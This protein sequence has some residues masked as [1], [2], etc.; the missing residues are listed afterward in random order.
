MIVD[1][2]ASEMEQILM[3]DHEELFI[4]NCKRKTIFKNRLIQRYYEY[5][6]ALYYVIKNH[7]KYEC[8]LFWQQIIGFFA[9]LYFSR[10]QTEKFIISSVL[11][12]PD[13]TPRFGVKR[14]LLFNAI[15]KA[16]AVL[17]FSEEMANATKRRYPMISPKIHSTLI[18]VFAEKQV[19]NGDLKNNSQSDLEG[20]IFCGGQSDRDF[21]TI[22]LAFRNT[23]IPVTIVCPDNYEIAMLSLATNNITIKRFSEVSPRDYYDLVRQSFCVVVSLKSR[24]SSCGQ[25]LF[26]FCMQNGIPIIA[27][28]SFGTRDY[29]KD[30]ENGLLVPIG[31]HVAFQNA[32]KRLRDNKSFRLR[33]IDRSKDIAESM[34]FANYLAKI[35]E[36]KLNENTSHNK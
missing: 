33:L 13:N 34:T 29:I 12:S 26:S 36:I 14:F 20:G 7:S 2:K 23:N 32:Y 11:Y 3:S 25:L 8:V 22:I 6:F 35:E 4:W 24:H 27:S 17:Y 5:L 19:S 21:D 1:W 10:K 18:P 15:K 30:K 16:K 9:A 31:D 28:D